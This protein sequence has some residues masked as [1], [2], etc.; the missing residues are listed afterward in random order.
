MDL[1]PKIKKIIQKILP[2]FILNRLDPVEYRIQNTVRE[3]ARDLPP[4]SRILDAGCGQNRF[5]PTFSRH[6]YLGYDQCVG[7]DKWDYSAV[8][9]VGDLHRLSIRNHT[10]DAGLCIVVLEHVQQPERVLSELF[11]VIKP[12]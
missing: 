6:F 8:D 9:L 2:D 1:N 11:R 3:F 10:M 5:K 12:R 4:D 7:D